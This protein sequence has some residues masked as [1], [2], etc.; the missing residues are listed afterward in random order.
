MNIPN[1][2]VLKE[3]GAGG[4]G[5]VYLAEHTLIKRKVAIKSLKQDL[6]KNEQLRERFKKE[7]TALA[8]L[9]HP[10]IVRLNEYI[11]QQDG[12]FLI[13]EY[14]DG[15]PL[16]EHI[17]TISGP[18]NEQQLIPLFLQVLDAFEY[19]HQNKI[20]HRDIK[21]SNI[22]ISKDDKI[23]ILDFGIAKIMD[24]TNSMTKTGTQMGSV[25]YMSPEQVRGEK[26][27]H[28]SDI[29]SIG[30]T[31]FQMATGKAPYDPTTNEYQVF[32]KID[33][34]PLPTASSI[35]PGISK[36][37]NEIIEK[38]TNKDDSKRFQSCKDFKNDI[39]KLTNKEVSENIK[40][41]NDSNK[42]ET[43]EKEKKKKNP[44]LI[45]III[46][47][48]LAGIGGYF[49][50]S[51]ASDIN[52]ENQIKAESVKLEDSTFV[53]EEEAEKNLSIS[54]NNSEE[55]KKTDN[56]LNDPKCLSGDCDNGYGTLVFDNGDKYIGNFKKGKFHGKGNFTYGKGSNKGDQYI[57]EFKNDIE[58]GKGTYTWANGD[59]YSGTFENGMPHG[60]GTYDYG[61]GPNE[62]DQYVGEFKEGLKAVF[63]TYTWANGVK[64]TGE[65]KNDRI[66][67][68]GEK[69]LTYGVLKGIWKNNILIKK[70][71]KSSKNKKEK[72]PSL[73]D[74]L[75]FKKK[76]KFFDDF[77]NGNINSW[78]LNS[79]YLS[80]HT[81]R[82]SICGSGSMNEYVNSCLK[83]SKFNFED[84]FLIESEICFS[85]KGITNPGSGIIFASDQKNDNFYAFTINRDGYY[86]IFKIE[87]GYFNY[88]SKEYCYSENLK[89]GKYSDNKLSIRFYN[90]EMTFLI[91]EKSVFK[92]NKQ[93]SFG[94]YYGLINFNKNCISCNYFKVENL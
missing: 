64:Y 40:E 93:K 77:S 54:V 6:I 16:D 69:K 53:I 51:S 57:G 74:V 19:A 14:V 49:F 59:K 86:K 2:K 58:S 3:I 79:G 25:L 29:Y 52:D 47:F 82:F 24:E 41:I 80:E 62:G 42:T 28:L 34:E 89:T 92:L 30:V 85:K 46:G 27:N 12:V 11:E 43:I 81:K 38:A 87:N 23:K 5:T 45:F 75:A 78:D 26:V 32:Q 65:F 20:V 1:Y 71:D 33:K 63:G 61:E 4:M 8:Q 15:L 17:N 50:I 88:L 7:A 70:E 55:K 21:P 35:Y 91:N 84:K 73:D 94:P 56:K 66:T 22:I 18:I 10:N 31:L 72:Y 13:M 83:F 76:F 90:N 67:G 44:I 60:K 68:Y 48:L 36:K 39:E 37:L 9:E